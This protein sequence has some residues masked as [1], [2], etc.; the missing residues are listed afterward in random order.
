MDLKD[1]SIAAERC[2][3]KMLGVYE[4][5]PPETTDPEFLELGKK[6]GIK[7]V[8]EDEL[9]CDDFSYEHA[10]DEQYRRAKQMII[11]ELSIYPKEVINKTR[12]EQVIFCTNLVVDKKRA[13]GTLK[14]GLH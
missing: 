8:T 1:L 4:L 6:Y 9:D 12:I 13:G 10:T 11:E 5:Q 7:F 3:A 14:V 2:F